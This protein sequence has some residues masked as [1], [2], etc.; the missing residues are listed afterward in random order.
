MAN[1]KFKR[2]VTG[3]LLSCSIVSFPFC[4][5]YDVLTEAVANQSGS[6]QLKTLYRVGRKVQE[7]YAKNLP[8]IKEAEQKSNYLYNQSIEELNELEKFY[9]ELFTDCCDANKLKKLKDDF[10]KSVTKDMTLASRNGTKITPPFLHYYAASKLCATARYR[11]VLFL[12]LLKEMEPPR[13]CTQLYIGSDIA[14]VEQLFALKATLPIQAFLMSLKPAENLAQELNN[15]TSVEEYRDDTTYEKTVKET[16]IEWSKRL[17]A[18]IFQGKLMVSPSPYYDPTC[19]LY[20]EYSPAKSP[21][22]TPTEKILAAK[23]SLYLKSSLFADITVGSNNQKS[24][25]KPKINSTNKLSWEEYYAAKLKGYKDRIL[26]LVDE[27]KSKLTCAPDQIKR[28]LGAALLDGKKDIDELLG[29]VSPDLRCLAKNVA[30]KNPITSSISTA[31][32]LDAPVPP[33]ALPFFLKPVTGESFKHNSHPHLQSH[34]AEDQSGRK[35]HG[36][37]TAP[38]SLFEK[39]N[40]I[41]EILNFRAAPNLLTLSVKL[42]VRNSDGEKRHL[43]IY[44]NYDPERYGFVM[45]GTVTNSETGSCTPAYALMLVSNE[46]NELITVYPLYL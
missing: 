34:L 25:L 4:L 36:N 18:K 15:Y 2:I 42:D 24:H 5:A 17:S 3:L 44:Y 32:L 39:M 23:Y 14:T 19:K 6:E 9:N 20:A 8:K 45:T 28:C 11:F 13:A 31:M 10:I 37:F 1:S 33:E 16:V 30:M 22:L 29:L 41:D 12:L 46:R 43:C 27:T 21:T 7:H 38:G 35:L 26:A 40:D